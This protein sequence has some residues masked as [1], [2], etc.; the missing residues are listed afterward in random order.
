MVCKDGSSYLGNRCTKFATIVG[1][2]VVAWEF[3]LPMALEYGL[4]AAGYLGA[5]GPIPYGIG[6]LGATGFGAA[7]VAG[8]EEAATGAAEEA[9]LSANEAFHYT[10]SRYISSI[11]SNGLRAGSYATKTGDLSP[12]QAQIDLALPPNR[13]LTDTILRIDLNGLRNAGYDIPEFM[14]VGRMFNIPGGGVGSA[15]SVLY[16]ARVHIGGEM[17]LDEFRLEMASYRQSSDNEAKLLKDSFVTLERLRTL[18]KTFDDT[19]RQMANEVLAEWALSE[20]EKL[21]FD[22]LALIDHFK[23]VSAMP[24]L[25]KLANRLASSTAPSAP[26]ELKKLSRIVAGLTGP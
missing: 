11:E 15:V 6:R 22:A 4:G 2:G 23:I 18:Y 10:F 17:T 5:S 24:A 7:G 14:Q 1:L 3:V 21:R 25:Q 13:G 9:A 20:D 8:I 16:P 26:F 12:L 19:E